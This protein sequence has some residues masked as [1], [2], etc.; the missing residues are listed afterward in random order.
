[1]KNILFFATKEDLLPVLEHV[2]GK[3][4]L[5]Y[6]R[7]G[8][9]P[10]RNCERYHR[11]ADL[12][13]LGKATSDSAISSAAYLVLQGNGEIRLRPFTLSSGAQQLAVDQLVNPDT[14]TFTPGGLWNQEALLYGRVATVSDSRPAQELM[15]R[16]HSA[17]KRTFTKI[18]AYY[19]GPR[20]DT[21]L[22]SG[23]RLT[24]AVQSPRDYDLQP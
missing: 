13:D 14:V 22:Q 15:R 16:F 17:V 18:K 9:F 24:S 1:M 11:G 7:S 3:G 10:S 6:V 19:V 5:T 20:A 23:M 4:K 2:E 21:L 12:P 8:N